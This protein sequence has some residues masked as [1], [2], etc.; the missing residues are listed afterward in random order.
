MVHVL[1]HSPFAYDVADA[2]RAYDWRRESAFPW[3]F[4]PTSS[5][6][7]PT[8]IFPDVFESERQACVFPLDDTDFAKGTSTDDS[9]ETEVVQVHWRRPKPVLASRTAVGEQQVSHGNVPSP[10]NS[11]GF[12]WLFPMASDYSIFF[13]PTS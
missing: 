4:N 12:P 10:S 8:F 2:F 6:E 1:E 9:Q 13:L 7:C 5:G 11:T 3:G